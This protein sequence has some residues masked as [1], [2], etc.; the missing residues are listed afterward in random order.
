MVGDFQEQLPSPSR[1]PLSREA[2]GAHRPGG[3]TGT[4]WC[5]RFSHQQRAG[6]RKLFFLL[7]LSERSESDLPPKD[8]ALTGGSASPL[9]RGPVS[10]SD[11][12]TLTVS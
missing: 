5:E 1:V 12:G 8:V 11:Q 3:C 6:E 9:P 7:K 2:G 10:L 4:T